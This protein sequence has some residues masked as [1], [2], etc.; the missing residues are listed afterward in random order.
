MEHWDEVRTAFYV[1]RE[2]TVSGA[3]EALGVHHATV[4]RHIDALEGRLGVKL[5]QRHARGYTPTEAGDDLARVARATDDQLAQLHGRLKG[6]GAEVSGELVVTS[7]PAMAGTLMPILT[8]F[9]KAHPEIV[10]RLLTGERLF[11]L[12]YGEAHVAIR[13][14]MNQPDQPDNVVQKFVKLPVGLYASRDYIEAHGPVGEDFAGHH[15]VGPDDDQ[16]RAPFLRWLLDNVPR[17]L[18]VFRSDDMRAMEQAVVDG[19]GIGFVGARRA[20]VD[21]LV[22]VSPMREDWCT[23]TWLVTHVDLHRTAKVQTFLTHIKSHMT[24]ILA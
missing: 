7:L 19:A 16:T 23:P 1:A 15:F 14:G 2:G 8:S 10:L 21:D 11:R 18:H 22:E 6:R 9:R 5:F 12:E 17:D 20:A 3:A 4:I 24:D 13:A